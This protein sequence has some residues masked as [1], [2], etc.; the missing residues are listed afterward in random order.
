MRV[1]QPGLLQLVHGPLRSLVVFGC[2][3]DPAPEEV[4]L[5]F[6]LQRETDDGAQVGLDALTLKLGIPRS[7]PEHR[8]RGPDVGVDG[9]EGR[10]DTVAGRTGKRLTEPR[11]RRRRTY[12]AT[13]SRNQTRG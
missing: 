3:A 10:H 6:A 5:R 11:G 4:A 2:A 9:V 1:F 8:R 12:G 13:L 7:R